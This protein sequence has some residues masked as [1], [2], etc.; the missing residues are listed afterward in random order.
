MKCYQ[1][2]VD[3]PLS[4]FIE[5]LVDK[6]LFALVISG[7]PSLEQLTAA[8]E[9]VMNEYSDIM[10]DGEG[11]LHFNL[12][13]EVELLKLD[14]QKVNICLQI[15]EAEVNFPDFVTPDKK[16]ATDLNKLS[17]SN[18]S[19]DHS[20]PDQFRNELKRATNRS[21]SLLILL[22]IKQSNLDAINTKANTIVKQPTKEYFYSI[23]NT[24]S[25]F[26]KFQLTDAITVYSFCDWIKKY[27]EH[28]KFLESQTTKK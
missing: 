21:K 19:F 4:K 27:N 1:S 15:L 5:C 20:K 25:M 7:E 3:L 28:T 18:F 22:G 14:I 12:L 6:N 13:K 2:I 16:Y 24:L 9:D 8:W 11:K 26:T 17:N 10:M 23:L